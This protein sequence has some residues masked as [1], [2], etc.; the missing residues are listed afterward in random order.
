MPIGPAPYPWSVL[1]DSHW[2]ALYHA[3]A[4]LIDDVI[5]DLRRLADGAPFSPLAIVA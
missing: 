5:E 2:E 1:P 4:E 3:N